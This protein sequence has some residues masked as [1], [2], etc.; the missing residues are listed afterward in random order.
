MI[1]LDLFQEFQSLLEVFRLQDI[2]RLPRHGMK[3]EVLQVFHFPQTK[4]IVGRR[5]SACPVCGLDSNPFVITEQYE[6]QLGATESDI[7]R[8]LAQ[9]KSIIH[10]PN[11]VPIL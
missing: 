2:L 8:F 5:K 11:G 3:N 7:A 10:M 9:D 6:A 4:R 1:R